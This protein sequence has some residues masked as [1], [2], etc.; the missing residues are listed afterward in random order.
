M[1]IN[2]DGWQDYR[3][4][5]A[6]VLVYVETS[7]QAAVPVRDQLNENGKGFLTEPNYET[8][9][10]GMKK[11]QNPR[12]I[13]SIIRNKH[14]YLIFG[15]RYEGFNEV[16]KDKYLIM[17]YMRI[18]KVKD[19]RSRHIHQYMA[20]PESGESEPE[21]VSMDKSMA[22]W[23][24][25]M[26]FV[27]LQDCYVLSEEVMKSWGYKGRVTRQMK[28]LLENEKLDQLLDYF[29]QKEDMTEEYIATVQE[30]VEALEEEEEENQTTPGW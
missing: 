4:D 29:S 14:R 16:F 15:T 21:C 23:S 30:F 11:C 7:H 18:D 20:N 24:N 1:A 6:G 9:T 5:H 12:T 2:L 25:D 3:G 10:Y 26:K 28:L 19:L 17:G 22:I 13:N 8:A 27:S